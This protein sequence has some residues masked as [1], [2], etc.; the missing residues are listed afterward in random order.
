MGYIVVLY[1]RNY[2]LLLFLVLCCF[3]FVRA[4]F[5]PCAG[6]VRKYNQLFLTGKDRTR[7]KMCGRKSWASLPGAVFRV[8]RGH[9]CL[10][11]AIGV[12]LSFVHCLRRSK[13]YTRTLAEKVVDA[14]SARVCSAPSLSFFVCFFFVNSGL[15]VCGCQRLPTTA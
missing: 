5:C 13:R 14:D 2:S 9:T 8:S 6:V 3:V 1:G 15:F 10:I 7:I 4:V 12:L 11:V